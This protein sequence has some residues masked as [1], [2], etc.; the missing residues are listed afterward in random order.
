MDGKT[1]PLAILF[2]SPKYFFALGCGLGCVP[3]APGTFGT[4]GGFLLA[5]L[6]LQISAFL[7]GVCVV[8]AFVLGCW[9]CQLTGEALGEVDHGAIV[10]DEIVA[11]AA[12]LLVLP[13]PGGWVSWTLAFVLFRLFDILKPWPIDVLERRFK[14]GFGVMLDDALAAVYALGAFAL[15]HSLYTTLFPS[16]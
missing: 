7:Q 13:T 16:P 11:F 14:N 3:R 9:L 10:W 4:L 2:R 5:L 15:L 1:A 8:V 12:L 6:L